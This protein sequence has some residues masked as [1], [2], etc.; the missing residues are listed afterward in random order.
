MKCETCQW[1]LMEVL[2]ETLDETNRNQVLAHVKTCPL[3]RKELEE[4]KEVHGILIRTNDEVEVPTGWL[5]RLE[6]NVNERAGFKT[7]GRVKR[8]WAG[9]VAALFSFLLVATAFATDGFRDF[10]T[11]WQDVTESDLEARDRVIEAGYGE[12]LNESVEHNGVRLTI[13]DVIADEIQTVVYYEVKDLEGDRQLSPV[14]SEG[15]H[16]KNEDEIWPSQ[17]EYDNSLGSHVNLYE[18]EE[19][20]N[21]GKITFGPI[22]TE[23]ASM[24]LLLTKL[25]FLPEEGTTNEES[26]IDPY[27]YESE[28]VEGEWSFEV[29]LTKHPLRTYDL[30]GEIYEVNGH[31]FKFQELLIGPTTSQLVYEFELNNEVEQEF[32]TDFVS[33]AGINVNGTLYEEEMFGPGVYSSADNS[34]FSS[35][36]VSFESIYFE[37]FDQLEIDFGQEMRSFDEMKEVSFHINEL[38]TSFIYLGNEVTLIKAE[39]QNGELILQ[40]EEDIDQDRVYDQLNANVKVEGYQTRGSSVMPKVIDE[41]GT[42]YGPEAAFAINE[43]DKP[44]VMSHEHYFRLEREEEDANALDQLSGTLMIQGHSSLEELNESIKVDLLKD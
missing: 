32:V 24:D 34:K 15:I 18:E 30:D 10:S 11:F 28:E 31:R 37:T 39:E 16:I 36:T 2:D 23:K 14:F 38:P 1:Q 13:T 29:S 5:S 12:R 20:F 7:T 17:E 8:W 22:E 3:C 33:L 4:L 35:A 40:V 21:Q 27:S 25:E 9:V 43:F 26:S 6:E 42:I 44:R 41:G 19:G